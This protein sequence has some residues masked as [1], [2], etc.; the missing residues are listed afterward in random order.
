MNFPDT[1]LTLLSR[2]RTRSLGHRWQHSWTTFF[3]CYY[4]PTKTCVRARFHRNNWTSVAEAD[5]NEVTMQVIDSLYEG[6]GL[7]ELDFA[8]GKFRQMLTVICSRRVA[9]FIRSRRRNQNDMSIEADGA[10]G[11]L[12]ELA[13]QQHDQLEDA[14]FKAAYV[15]TLL[16]ELYH[17]VSP[18]TYQI[19]ERV[20]LLG[21]EPDAVAEDLGIKRGVIDNTIYKTKKKLLE[22][23]QRPE[24]RKE[25]EL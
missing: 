11:G 14:G 18:Q 12:N 9:D 16:E 1:P 2:L 23:A 22:I 15:A 8:K 24:I 19:F 10:T 4:N 7:V 17:E 13:H 6:G 3:D 20:K 5:L 21:E 25:F